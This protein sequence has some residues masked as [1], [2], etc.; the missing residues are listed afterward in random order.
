[1]I[2]FLKQEEI[3]KISENNLDFNEKPKPYSQNDIKE[4]FIIEKYKIKKFLKENKLNNKEENI[5]CIIKAIDENHYCSF[6][7]L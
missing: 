7:N 4:E 3:N 1:M 5:E 2:N 6:I